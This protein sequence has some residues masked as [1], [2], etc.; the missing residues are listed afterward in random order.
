[1]PK[2]E[3]I[4]GNERKDLSWKKTMDWQL[5]YTG[6]V[7]RSFANRKMIDDHLIIL[8]SFFKHSMASSEISVET[9]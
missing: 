5:M 8:G 4:N 1:M 6:D 3:S 2:N 7:A 9:K